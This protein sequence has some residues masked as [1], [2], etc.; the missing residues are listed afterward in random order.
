MTVYVSF[1]YQKSCKL[2]YEILS[3]TSILNK[4]VEL[5]SIKIIVDSVDV[6]QSNSNISIIELLVSNRGKNH[7]RR[8]DYDNSKFGLL[9]QNGTLL[10]KPEPYLLVRLICEIVLMSILSTMTALF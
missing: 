3:N 1:F 9:I 8:D 6:Q 7:L 5:S 2:E 10:E 4:T